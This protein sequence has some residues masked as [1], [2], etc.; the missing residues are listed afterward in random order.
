MSLAFLRNLKDVNVCASKRSEYPWVQ[1][2]DYRIELIG[3]NITSSIQVSHA[4]DCNAN[5]V[6]LFGTKGVIKLDLQ[7]MLLT[8]FKRKYLNPFSVAS[9]SLSVASQTVRGVMSNFF[10]FLLGNSMLGHDIMI[11]KFV[12]SIKYDKPVPVKPEDGMETV[13]V[14]EMIVSKLDAINNNPST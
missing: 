2:D 4:G 8:L 12:E 5:E 14:M 10:R 13:R 6:D 9:S 11:K 7:A 1:F 3:E